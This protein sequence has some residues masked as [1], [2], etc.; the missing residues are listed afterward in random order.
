MLGGT[1]APCH[2]TSLYVALGSAS[3]STT[4]KREI[5]FVRAVMY[6]TLVEAYASDGKSSTPALRTAVYAFA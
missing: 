1:F 2:V 5:S 4:K 3:L 6:S